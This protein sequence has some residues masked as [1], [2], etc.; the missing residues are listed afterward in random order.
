MTL[1]SADSDTGNLREVTWTD[2]ERGGFGWQFTP[3]GT[4][5]I[6][7]INGQ[8]VEIPVTG[9][10]SKPLTTNADHPSRLIDWLDASD[11][12]LYQAFIDANA[13]PETR[14]VLQQSGQAGVSLPQPNVYTGL[15]PVVSPNESAIAA[16]VEKSPLRVVVYDLTGTPIH[17]ITVD[18]DDEAYIDLNGLFWSPDSRYLSLQ[19]SHKIYIL[20]TVE[21]TSW[22]LTEGDSRSPWLMD[23]RHLLYLGAQGLC[24]ISI[25]QGAQPTCVLPE[26]ASVSD[27]DFPLIGTARFMP[28]YVETPLM[29]GG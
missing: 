13:G 1:H 11:T 8:I 18:I 21:E 22:K 12:V 15:S 9:G 23:A 17:D 3:D 16:V 27:Y 25:E 2:N 14:N 26:L 5:Y 19:V 6:V 24:T 7:A 20:D 29:R 4:K 28:M 10:N